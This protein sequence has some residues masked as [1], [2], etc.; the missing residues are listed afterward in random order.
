MRRKIRNIL[1]WLLGSVCLAFILAVFAEWFIEVA[2][3]KG[4]YDGAGQRWDSI[5]SSVF[6]LTSNPLV[7]VPLIG[8]IGIAGGMWLDCVLKYM[9]NRFSAKP[10]P[11]DWDFLESEIIR[12]QLYIERDIQRR[13]EIKPGYVAT[14]QESIGGFYALL[15]YLHEHGMI[16]DA[17]VPNP[18]LMNDDDFFFEMSTRFLAAIH[19][20]VRA[21]NKD[22]VRDF[23]GGMTEL[24]YQW[25][26]DRSAEKTES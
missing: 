14:S 17:G 10:K 23:G 6:S 19:P 13:T 20:F 26:R 5:A 16:S 12:L 21:K 7:Y 2:K 24:V 1:S 18:M 4:W 25:E 15:F 9:N 22:A 3:D 11:V 8:F